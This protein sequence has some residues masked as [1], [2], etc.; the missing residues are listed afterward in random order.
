MANTVFFAWQ[1]D[2]P[3]S[4]NKTFVWN[5]LE[6]ALKIAFADV[7]PELSPR[8]EVDTQGVTGAP[9]IVDTIF[10]RIRGSSVFIADLT[11][12]ATTARGKAIPNPNVMIE[13]GYAARSIGWERTILVM[14]SAH[15]PAKNLPFDVIQ[16]R[17]PIEFR[18]T[19]QTEVREKRYEKLAQAL[20]DAILACQASELERATEMANSLDTSTLNFV[21]HHAGHELI[22]MPLPPRTMGEHIGGIVEIGAARRL[23]ELGAI[24]IRSTPDFGY[25]WTHDGR[26]MI[27]HFSQ[28]HPTLLDVLRQ[29]RAAKST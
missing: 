23:I 21:A 22:E 3:V 26:A 1:A 7:R 19:G 14:N 5:A 6:D 10:K 2:T 4:D 27:A 28:Q 24:R 25:V 13:L 15:G 18:V 9:N 17:W 11:F 29:H 8:P 20:G 12:V 16:H